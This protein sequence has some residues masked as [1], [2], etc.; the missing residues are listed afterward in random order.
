MWGTVAKLADEPTHDWRNSQSAATTANPMVVTA[1]ANPPTRRA[2]RPTAA[3]TAAPTSPAARSG[4]RTASSDFGALDVSA[5]TIC[6]TSPSATPPPRAA[7]SE[8]NAPNAA[9]PS[10][11]IRRYGPKEAMLK[12]GCVGAWNTADTADSPP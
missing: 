5:D 2:G 4:M 6:P 9:A 10:V 12:L 8:T 1:R 3:I 7:G 11:N